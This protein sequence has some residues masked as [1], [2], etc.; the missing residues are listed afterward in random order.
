MKIINPLFREMG[1]G[2]SEIN[3]LSIFLKQR[4]CKQVRLVG[5]E[6]KI[7]LS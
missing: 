2:A 3:F 7:K 5:D 1:L 6:V 4:D